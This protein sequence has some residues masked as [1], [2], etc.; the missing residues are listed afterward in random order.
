MVV[1]AKDGGGYDIAHAPE[2]VIDPT[3]MADRDGELGLAVTG[4]PAAG[5][6]PHVG[7]KDWDGAEALAE[8]TYRQAA[9]CPMVHLTG[10]ASSSCCGRSPG[11][12]NARRCLPSCGK[13]SFFKVSSSANA[14]SVGFIGRVSRIARV[15]QEGLVEKVRPG[16]PRA[17]YEKRVLLGLSVEDQ[18]IV[19]NQLLNHLGE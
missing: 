12:S 10:R 3:W 1:T 18:H 17:H 6:T 15:H 16:G 5:R 7:P 4:P 14:V 13:P 2:P 9:S 11:G 8:P 19:R